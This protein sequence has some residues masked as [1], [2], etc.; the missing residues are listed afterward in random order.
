MTDL[1]APLQAPKAAPAYPESKSG[2]YLL[3][4][5]KNEELATFGAGCYWGTEKYFVIDFQKKNKDAL[6]GYSVGFMSP[7]SDAKASPTY[8]EVRKGDTTHVEVLHMKYDKDKVSYEDLVKYFF[9]FHDP[10]QLNY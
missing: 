10:T 1:M 8:A 3:A 5:G 9:T 2:K 6:L 4:D 7:H